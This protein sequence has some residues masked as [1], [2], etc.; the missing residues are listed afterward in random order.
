[1][2]VKLKVIHG[3][4]KKND[5]FQVVVPITKTP[6]VFGRATDCD[7]RCHSPAI[8]RRH[9]EIRVAGFDITIVDLNSRNG[10]R[11]NGE[12]IKE[13]RRLSRHWSP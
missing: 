10:V 11:V 7:M 12:F 13:E 3:A 8:S 1:M 6:F 2:S 4:L 9:C 5:R